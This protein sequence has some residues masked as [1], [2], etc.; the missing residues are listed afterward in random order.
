MDSGY[1]SGTVYDY[2]S[3]FSKY[4]KTGWLWNSGW[5][6]L[7]GSKQERFAHFPAQGKKVDRL[8]SPPSKVL[9][10][11]GKH[12]RLISWSNLIAKDKL[13][14]LRASGPD[15][16]AFPNDIGAAYMKHI[17][18]E[19]KRD[20]VD[21]TTK[22]ITQRYVPLHSDNHAWDC[23]AMQVVAASITHILRAS[24]EAH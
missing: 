3:R 15:V 18:S 2:C 9:G 10:T 22:A 21:K 1:E 11:N 20:V 13:T 16:W 12:C 19:V 8:F 23:E 7:K 4:D 6:A 5:T 14:H 17:V 24:Q